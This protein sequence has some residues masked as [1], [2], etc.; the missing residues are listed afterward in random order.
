MQSPRV[1]ETFVQLQPQQ[2]EIC[3]PAQILV[4]DR[5]NG[6]AQV[7]MD[8]M[9][10]L[11]GEEIAVTEITDYPSALPLL[12]YSCYDLVVL[13]WE[14]SQAVSPT[15]LKYLRNSQPDLAVLLIGADM[16]P[17]Y[18]DFI[19][20]NGVT[21]AINLPTRAAEVKWLTGHISH[22]YLHFG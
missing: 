5:S 8:T 21:E 1:V 9:S 13:G 18:V 22:H 4:I 10:R 20:F 6:P 3:C 2:H 15:F 7:L 17:Q 19:E 11:L 12:D 14:E 16:S